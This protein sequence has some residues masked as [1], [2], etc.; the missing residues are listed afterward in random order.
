MRKV[1]TLAGGRRYGC[2]AYASIR[3]LRYLGCKLPIEW[4]Y[5]NEVE[6]PHNWIKAV[7]AISDVTCI[8]CNCG[9]VDNRKERGGWQAKIKSIL[10]SNADEILFMDADN[11]VRR[12][13]T[14]LF[15]SDLYKEHGAVLW[16]DISNWEKSRLE[17]IKK[18]FGIYPQHK[19]QTESGQMLFD[20]NRCLR[21]LEQT[22]QY[23]L[24]SNHAYKI[25]YGDKDTFYFGFLATNTPFNFIPK[26]PKC[27]FGCLLQHDPYDEIVFTHLTGG[28]WAL[29][30]RQFTNKDSLPH[31]Y[32]CK[33]FLAELRDQLQGE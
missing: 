5:L 27:G 19:T 21:A 8:N 3:L 29:H 30:G 17:G 18:Y 1:I 31:L 22:A 32:K 12:D 6:M 15:D 10:K 23:N 9:G 16:P 33:E 2:N 13:P 14:Y 11:F 28:K 26:R 25:V 24:D 4:Y 20:K 7:E